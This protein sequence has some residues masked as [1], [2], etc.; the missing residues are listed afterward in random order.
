MLVS[1][2]ANAFSPEWFRTQWNRAKNLAGRRFTEQLDVGLPLSRYF[3]SVTFAGEFFERFNTEADALEESW[4]KRPF[5]ALSPDDAL[6]TLSSEVSAIISGC[7]NLSHLKELH[8]THSPR[9]FG[10]TCLESLRD[11]QCTLQRSHG[12][13]AQCDTAGKVRRRIPCRAIFGY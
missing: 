13:A 8:L 1:P 3:K 6:Q 5:Q 4:R 9:L 10:R 7:G 12:E 11:T 2:Q